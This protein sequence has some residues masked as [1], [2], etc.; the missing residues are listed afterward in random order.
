MILHLNRSERL[1]LLRAIDFRLAKI[2]ARRAQRATKP[3][4][5]T[6]EN[7]LG[8]LRDELAGDRALEVAR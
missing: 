5:E 3:N 2:G 6:D 1:A 7:L 8:A 4:D